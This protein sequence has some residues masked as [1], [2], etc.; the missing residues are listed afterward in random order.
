MSLRIAN[1][2]INA[3]KRRLDE[4][5]SAKKE[6]TPL[7]NKIDKVFAAMY[8]DNMEYFKKL[9]EG[10]RWGAYDHTLESAVPMCVSHVF[11]PNAGYD[12]KNIKTV[13]SKS[14][15]EY[16]DVIDTLIDLYRLVESAHVPL[17]NGE[18]DAKIKKEMADMGAAFDRGFRSSHVSVTGHHCVNESGTHW[19]RYDWYLEGHRTAYSTIMNRIA[20]D[21]KNWKAANEPDMSALTIFEIN[22]FYDKF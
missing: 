21:F 16:L 15:P 22:R 14:C 8:R 3:V 12:I 4:P 7:F 6:K 2:T 10:L 9:H 19:V 5:F 20:E 17:T 18:E 11:N 1:N 13:L